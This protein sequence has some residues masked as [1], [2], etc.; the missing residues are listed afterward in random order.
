M[1]LFSKA[2]NHHNVRNDYQTINEKN[3]GEKR[4]NERI[5]RQFI[6]E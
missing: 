5:L 3:A 2:N 6:H 4:R 1:S